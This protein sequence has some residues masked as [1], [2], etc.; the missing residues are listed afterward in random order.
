MIRRRNCSRGRPVWRA[1]ALSRKTGAAPDLPRRAAERRR[2]GRGE[3][4]EGDKSEGSGILVMTAG[5][6]LHCPF[7]G[8]YTAVSPAPLVIPQRGGYVRDF[9][10]IQQQLAGDLVYVHQGGLWWLAKCN[11]CGMPLIVRDNGTLVFPVPQPG[12]VSDHVPEPMRSD[13]R[14]AKQCIAAGAWNA[15]VVMARRALQ[16]AVVEQGAPTG[17]EWPLWTQIKWMDDNRKI[18]V[19]QREWADAARWVGN[20]G[21]HDTEPYVPEGKPV[22]TDVSEDDA[23][24]TLELVEHLFDAIYVA[25]HLAREQL[26][27]RGKL[28]GGSGKA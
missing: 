8:R 23:R 3:Q 11:A 9:E 22:I 21:A 15:A 24:A 13:V 19:Q 10:P 12:P 2:G 6:S 5:I 17:R 4:Q 18:T 26:A 14:E 16:C 27:K 25:G 7:C 28:P 1:K 20:H